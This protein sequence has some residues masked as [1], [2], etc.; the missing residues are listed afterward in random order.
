MYKYTN[1]YTCTYGECNSQFTPAFNLSQYR[2]GSETRQRKTR[3]AEIV[4]A[5]VE[6]VVVV[7][8]SSDSGAMLNPRPMKPSLSRPASPC[9]PR[10][11]VI[12]R[13]VVA[14]TGGKN[15]WPATSVPYAGPCYH[16]RVEALPATGLIPGHPV[17]IQRHDR[18]EPTATSRRSRS[19]MYSLMYACFI[20][21][22]SAWCARRVVVSL[23]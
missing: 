7:V 15:P 11:A 18:N 14:A 12:V 17:C 2:G 13:A 1:I 10:R 19:L 5:A 9:R 3:Q 23:P 20:R 22:P 4:Q 6:V 21:Q 16:P 8:G